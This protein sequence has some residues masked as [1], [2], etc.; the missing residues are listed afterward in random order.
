MV[1]FACGDNDFEAYFTR[2]LA[3]KNN[4]V[5]ISG[6]YAAEKIVRLLVDIPSSCKPKVSI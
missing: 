5:Y 2:L 1:A 3:E 6:L 4:Q